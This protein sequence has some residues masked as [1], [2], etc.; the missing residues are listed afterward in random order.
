GL[1]MRQRGAAVKGLGEGFQVDV[2]RVNMIVDVVEG[3]ACD[4]TVRDHNRFDAVLLRSVTDVY[5]VFAPYGRF[6]VG[7]GDRRASVADG[8]HHDV[9]RGHEGRPHLVCARFRY[10]P[11][12]AEKTA[13]V[14][15]GGPHRKDARA[16][17]K[18]I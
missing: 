15:S 5:D 2:G 8:E 18:M 10:V 7:E 14:A 13:H 6:V 4:V 9:L 17:Q 1:Q 3:L 12:L 16:G 11:V